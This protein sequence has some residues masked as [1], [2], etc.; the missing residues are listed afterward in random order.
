MAT[1]HAPH[2]PPP[3][4]LPPLL[5]SPAARAGIRPG[6]RV[7]AIDGHDTTGMDRESAAAAMRGSSGSSVVLRV[8][9]RADP[10]PPPTPGVPSR[11]PPPPRTAVRAVR[12]TRERVELSPV[13]ASLVDGHV[14][15][16]RL[17][18]FTARAAADVRAAVTRLAAD[19]ATSY[20]LD[21]RDNGG[22][23]VRSGL[24]VASV[25]LGGGAP[26]FNVAGR[27]EPAATS[28]SILQRV[29]LPDASSAAVA[30]ST[31][32]AVLVDHG[33]AS[34]AEIVAGALRDNHRATLVGARTYGKGK[35]QTVYPLQDGSALFVTV[36]RYVTPGNHVIDGRGIAPD[37]AC[38]AGAAPGVGAPR[39]AASLPGLADLLAA[40]LQ[41][42]PCVQQAEVMLERAARRA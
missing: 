39:L 19:G 12:L 41:D 5:I 16:V 21:L 31:P 9:S 10:V 23:L 1:T 15:Y 30:P 24:D 32:L 13:T 27:S 25:W 11:A 42:D 18:S 36:A 7:L 37:A 20:I 8:A 40:G 6:D 4:P 38:R 3:P 29:V 26:V 17:A 2:P 34:A 14:G 35:I 22:G 28:P 33:S